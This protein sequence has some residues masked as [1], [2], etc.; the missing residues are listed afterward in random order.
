M[1]VRVYWS[2]VKVAVTVLSPSMVIESGLVEPVR[3]PLHAEKV[4]PASGVA[5]SWT[6]SFK[7]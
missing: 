7:T 6:T 2:W 4:Q 1:T 3:S 5:V